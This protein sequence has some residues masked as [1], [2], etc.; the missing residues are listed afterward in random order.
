MGDNVAAIFVKDNSL[1]RQ[2]ERTHRKQ[3]RKIIRLKIK[4]FQPKTP[5]IQQN[6]DNAVITKHRGRDRIRMVFKK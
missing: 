2:R 3:Y 6:Q 5:S 4:L 1:K